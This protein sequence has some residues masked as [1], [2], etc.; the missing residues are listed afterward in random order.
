MFR[1]RVLPIALTLLV[2]LVGEGASSRPVRAYDDTRLGPT[3]PR[4]GFLDGDVSFW[5]PGAEDWAPAQ[6][7]TALAAGDSLYAGDRGTFELEIGP[8]AFVRAGAN[9]ELGLES[10]GPS[11][12]QFK[13]TGG[14]AAFDLK[15]LARG[16]TLEIDTPTA[17]FTVDR[18]GYYRVDV[19]ENNTAFS[20]RRGGVAT[21]VPASGETADVSE[22]Q[23]AI[24]EGAESVQVNIDAAPDLD[25]WDRW[26]YDR[27]A[28]LSEVP[29]SAQYV[30]P[31]V[32]GVDDLDRYGDWREAPRYGHVW[33]PRDIPPDWAP[34]SAGRWVYD[35][36]YEWTWVDD[37]PWGW[38]P[39]HYG[40][41]VHADGFWGWAPGPIVVAPVYA[42]A[43]VAFF[44][45]PGVG[46]SVSV[47]LPFVSWVALGFGEP[48]IPWWGG[49]GF[50]GR[51]FWGGWGGRRIVNNVVVNNT[52]IVNVRNINKFQNVNVRNAVVAVSREQFGRGR[53][54]PVRLDPERAQRLKPTRGQLGVTP[55]AASLVPKEGRGHRPPERLRARPVVATRPSQDTAERLRAKGLNPAAQT[56][57][58][59]PRI[60]KPHRGPQSGPEER[61]QRPEGIGVPPERV[62][63]PPPAHGERRRP[64]GAGVPPERVV[65]PP[66]AHGERRRPEGV[67]VPPERVVPPPPAHGERR[68]PEGAGVPPERVVPPPPAHGER[69][70][71]EGVGVP[72]EG[73]APPPP[74]HG[75]QPR[76][77]RP[78]RAAPLSPQGERHRPSYP[79]V[80]GG[81]PPPPPPAVQHERPSRERDVQPLRGEQPGRHAPM[82]SRAQPP[83][84]APRPPVEREP[85]PGHKPPSKVPPTGPDDGQRSPN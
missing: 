25:E 83:R 33:V 48:V 30:P 74:A 19:D 22:N 64:E 59:Q 82:P 20:A 75:E 39:Y 84:E 28:R 18:A 21:V 17:A 40:R 10:L 13:V 51:P 77:G 12:L 69:R 81:A 61:R 54:E 36:Y 73:V 15:R 8:R 55:V 27:T 23:R 68:Q 7:N 1:R 62:V 3:P 29:R 47:G 53:V 9:T 43:L 32:A 42:P 63:P 60:V 52:T 16:Q 79:G 80:E 72:P 46:V 5:R 45:A 26:N 85:H 65:P 70:R 35:P 71:P 49:V 57:P 34:Y 24:L 67:G 14:H 66:P 41:W 50:V 76:P 11:Y 6:V 56:A 58:P 37:A 38:C 31:D 78:E 4:L 44:G 2:A